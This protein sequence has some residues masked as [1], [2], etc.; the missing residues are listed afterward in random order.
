MHPADIK[1]ALEK[2]GCDQA[3]IARDLDVSKTA[4]NAVIYDRSRSARIES[5]IAEVTGL[6]TDVLW[7][8]HRQ[9]RRYRGPFAAMQAAG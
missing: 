2:A 3:Q 6:S 4:V 5:R 1:A 7:P 9:K 8:Q